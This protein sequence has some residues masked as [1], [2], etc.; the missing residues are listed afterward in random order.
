MFKNKTL[1]ITGGTGSFGNAVMKRFLNT[2]IKE[3]RIFSRDEKK[4]DDMRKLYKNDILYQIIKNT[5]RFLQAKD[6]DE[7]LKNILSTIGKVTN[8]DVLAYYKCNYT[9][10]TFD[11]KFRW[12]KETDSLDVLNPKILKVPFTLLSD[13]FETL[14]QNEPYHSITRKITHEDTKKLFTELNTKSALIL[15][16]FIKDKLYSMIVFTVFEYE[17]EWMS[18]EINTLTTLTNNIAFAIER[19]LNEIIIKENEEKFKLLANN[20]P[21]TVHLSKYD[22]KWTKIYLNDEIENLTGYSKEEFLLKNI[23]FI[24]LVNLQ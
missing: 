21:G 22:E 23:Y 2:D 24:D 14:N 9:D 7:I 12:N 4:Q 15:P 11:Q 6:N 16:I 8:V 5:E 17:R 1:L 20:I 10:S 18:D 19:N 3:I 13:I